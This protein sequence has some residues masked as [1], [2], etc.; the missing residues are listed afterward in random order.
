M[1]SSSWGQGWGLEEEEGEEGE[2][3]MERQGRGGFRD[4]TRV[5]GRRRGGDRRQV[6]LG[7]VEVV[8]VVRVLGGAHAAEVRAERLRGAGQAGLLR[9]LRGH[10]RRLCQLEILTGREKREQKLGPLTPHHTN[11]CDLN[12]LPCNH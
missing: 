10:G 4:L 1:E 8:A 3:G 7:D 11:T 5:G 6:H 12:L 9:L 2:A